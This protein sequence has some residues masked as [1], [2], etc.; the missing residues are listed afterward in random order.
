MNSMSAER[1]EVRK[2]TQNSASDNASDSASDNASDS[3]DQYDV[4]LG[5]GICIHACLSVHG[6]IV[7]VDWNMPGNGEDLPLMDDVFCKENSVKK[8]ESKKE[9]RKRK[10]VGKRITKPACVRSGKTNGEKMMDI[11][12]KEG[13]SSSSDDSL[14]EGQN[15][16]M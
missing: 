1:E 12:E 9:S 5:Q 6:I 11:L 2:S 10:H 15:T 13:F 7:D 4:H 16:R 8:A 3:T 14:E